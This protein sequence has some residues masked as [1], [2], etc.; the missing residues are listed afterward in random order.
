MCR[1]FIFHAVGANTD[2]LSGQLAATAI[3]LN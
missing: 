3:Q 1:K 2:T